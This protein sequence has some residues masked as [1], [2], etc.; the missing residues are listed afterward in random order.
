MEQINLI[1]TKDI[2]RFTPMGGNVG[3]DKYIFLIGIVQKTV[4]EPV[5][6]TKLYK[7]ILSDY[8]D[9]LLDDLYL[10]MYEDYIQPFV[11]YGTYAKYV[12]SGS[13]RIRNNGDVKTTPNNSQIMTNQENVSSESEYQNLADKYLMDLEKFLCYEGNNIPEY[14]DQDNAYDKRSKNND[15][16]SLTWW[17][18][19]GGSCC[20]GGGHV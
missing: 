18:G 5:L 11:V 13:N 20:G 2:V 16:Y 17:L 7:K 12:H 4:L 6:G 14:R 8:K 10:Q 19:N 9:D 3:I 15:G 1:E